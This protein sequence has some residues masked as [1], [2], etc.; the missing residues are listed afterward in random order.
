MLSWEF[1]ELRASDNGMLGDSSAKPLAIMSDCED[2]GIE[3]FDS[4]NFE[5]YE[6]AGVGVGSLRPADE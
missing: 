4:V 5:S 3:S 2:D 6:D 1:L